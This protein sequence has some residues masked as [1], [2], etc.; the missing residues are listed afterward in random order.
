M[1]E[2]GFKIIKDNNGDNVYVKS[3]WDLSGIGIK[4]D[5]KEIYVRPEILCRICW[6]PVVLRCLSQCGV[7][8]VKEEY[9]C[10]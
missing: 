5:S 3:D 9:S 2:I 4:K 7:V 6:V 1:K 8:I 10:P